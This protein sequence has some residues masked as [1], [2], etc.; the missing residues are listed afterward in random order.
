[1]T[2]RGII[3]SATVGVAVMVVGAATWLN[4][5][6]DDNSE[7]IHQKG[8][9]DFMK[10]Y[11]ERMQK[12]GGT[13]TLTNPMPKFEAEWEFADN[14][15]GFHVFLPQKWKAELVQHFTQVFG[16]PT[17]R[18]QSSQMS[19][20]EDRFNVLITAGLD[21]DPIPIVCLKRGL[22]KGRK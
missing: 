7:I 22:L 21:S 16:E 9:G 5:A 19:Y 18:A 6:G 4:R 15:N 14:P 11:V 8:A 3:W 1:M 13:V 20:K 10:F 2:K 12:Y 17:S